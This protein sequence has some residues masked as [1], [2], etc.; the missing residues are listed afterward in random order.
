MHRRDFI[1]LIGGAAASWPLAAHA[2]Q[3]AMPVIGVLS[4][5]S[6][7]TAARNL[8]ALRKGLLE[9]G[10]IEGRNVRVEYR[11]AQGAPERYPALMAELIALDP[12]V[13]IVGSIGAILAAS[14]I[15]RTIPLIMFIAADNPVALG[16]VESFARPGGNV[17]GFSLSSDAE[18]IGKR[19]ELLREA[20]PGFSRIGVLV[21][22]VDA[23]A[24]GTLG[25]LPSAARGLGL[26][27]RVYAVQSEVELEAAFVT[28]LRDGIQAL[29]V[30]QTPLF[31]NRRTEIVARVASMRLPAIYFF[32]EF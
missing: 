27:A 28:A 5:Q 13:I 19:L 12:A 21:N 20:S 10:Y 14:K 30:S 18:I 25:A 22:H 17:T 24:D 32:R 29:Y 11:F 26:D 3:A 9:L 31:L 1:T 8:S 16:L 23:T 2:Q 15:T 4:P 6:V 7:A